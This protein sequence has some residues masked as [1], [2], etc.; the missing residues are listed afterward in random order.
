VIGFVKRRYGAGGWHLI[1]HL[2]A[3]AVAAYALAQIVHGGH[4]VNFAVWFAGAA[5]LHDVVFLPLYSLL[6]RL[7]GHPA[8]RTR[9]LGAVPLINHMRVP[10]LI[11]GLLLLVYFPLIFG[12]A[13]RTYLAASGHHPSGYARNWALISAALFIASG[14]LYAVRV[15]WRRRQSACPR[16]ARVGS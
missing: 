8:R 2:T 14:T 1:G 11:S 9:P 6:D 16:H 13:Q 4:V 3:F 5:L 15:L 7:V 10:A 12:T